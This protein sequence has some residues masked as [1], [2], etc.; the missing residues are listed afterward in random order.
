MKIRVPKKKMRSAKRQIEVHR[1]TK[2]R[3]MSAIIT[4]HSA[5]K[6]VCALETAQAQ[7]VFT[8]HLQQ[9]RFGFALEPLLL[10][11]GALMFHF[12]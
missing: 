5:C 2:L 8:L 7:A 4:R 10:V 12:R 9:N 1:I 6:S 3:S 11:V